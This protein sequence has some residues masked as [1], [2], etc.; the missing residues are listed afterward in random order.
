M[1]TSSGTHSGIDIEGAGAADL[2]QHLLGRGVHGLEGAAIN[3][4]GEL[5]VDEQ[6]IRGLDVDD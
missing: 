2:R 3:R 5:A 6:A 1:R 4:G